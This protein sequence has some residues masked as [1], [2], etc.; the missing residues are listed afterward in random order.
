[1]AVATALLHMYAESGDP[2]SAIHVFESMTDKDLIVWNCLIACSARHGLIDDAFDLFVDMQRSGRLKPNASTLAGLLP[3]VAHSGS[4]H[5]CKS[6]HAFM[7]RNGIESIEPAST[8]LMDAYA[9]CSDVPAARALFDA[10]REPVMVAWTSIIAAHGIQGLGGEALSL[11]EVMKASGVKPNRVTY[12]AVL[13][14]C[15]HAGL[16]ERG[17]ECFRL[18][19][20]HG[21]AREEEHY[22]CMVDMLGRARLFEEAMRVIG[23]MRAGPSA[24]VWE[25][26]LGGCRMHGKVALGE[27]VAGRLFGL[28]AA[29]PGLYVLLSNIYASAGLWA[30]VGRVRALMRARGLKKEVGWS[31]VEV[32]GRPVR[33]ISGDL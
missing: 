29:K 24:G 15:A 11:F 12:L 21:I 20:E 7:V 4:L 27:Y 33:F 30:E 3:A 13:S 28:G 22:A 32:R 14:A 31:S 16:V 19:E 1:M 2:E 18:M 17:R 25:A 23:L 10:M 26:L 8:A 6:C 5:S 9:K